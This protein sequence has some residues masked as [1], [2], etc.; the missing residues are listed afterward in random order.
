L[1]VSADAD[2]RSNAL[3][4]A[5]KRARKLPIPKSFLRKSGSERKHGSGIFRKRRMCD[6]PAVIR[7]KHCPV[8][9]TY[10]HLRIRSVPGLSVLP[11]P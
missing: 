4:F 7:V 1:T 9:P 3:G 2:A 6:G 11:K 8:G 5:G 10:T